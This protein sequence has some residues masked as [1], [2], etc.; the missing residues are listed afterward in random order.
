MSALVFL[1]QGLAVLARP[2]V[3]LPLLLLQ[4]HPDYLAAHDAGVDETVLERQGLRALQS[5]T[6]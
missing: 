4:V 6:L 3:D 5:H 2:V 1:V